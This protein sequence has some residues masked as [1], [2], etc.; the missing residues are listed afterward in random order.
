MFRFLRQE[1]QNCWD[2]C[3]LTFSL[4]WALW[5]WGAA[6]ATFFLLF[7]LLY[8]FQKVCTKCGIETFGAQKRHL[9]LCKICSEQREVKCSCGDGA[10]QHVPTCPMSVLSVCARR[11]PFPPMGRGAWDGLWEAW[12]EATQGQ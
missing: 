1:N 5:L 6:N 4:P 8:L 2:R 10:Q 7:F 11:C 12:L 3:F 9:W